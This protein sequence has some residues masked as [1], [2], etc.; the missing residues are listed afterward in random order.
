MTPAVEP[1]GGQPESPAQAVATAV[2]AV[3]NPLCAIL[4]L[5]EF[6]LADAAPGTRSR[7]RLELIHSSALEIREAVR[8][9]KEQS[10]AW[11]KDAS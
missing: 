11:E 8:T 4:G 1:I 2:H 6:L 10:V 9:L 7:E 5:L 3:N